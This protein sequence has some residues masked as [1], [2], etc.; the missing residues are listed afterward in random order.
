MVSATTSGASAVS[1]EQVEGK[2]IVSAAWKERAQSV[3]TVAKHR[4]KLSFRTFL[5]G[6][7][8]I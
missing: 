5:S 2:A 6:T 3:D 8:S 4:T 7:D 1:A